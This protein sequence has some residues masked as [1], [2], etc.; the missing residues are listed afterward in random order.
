MSTS[1]RLGFAADAPV[2]AFFRVFN[3][4]FDALARLRAAGARHWRDLARC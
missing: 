3:R 2:H 4:L 1:I